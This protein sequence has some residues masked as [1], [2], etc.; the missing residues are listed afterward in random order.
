[1]HFLAEYMYLHIARTAVSLPV[2]E[3]HAHSCRYISANRS[4]ETDLSKGKWP[5]AYNAGINA[6]PRGLLHVEDEFC[7]MMNACGATLPCHRCK[8]YWVDRCVAVRSNSTE[9]VRRHKV[10]ANESHRV[11]NLSCSGAQDWSRR[12][13]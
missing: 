6:S 11:P 1:M 3:G 4:L 10:L 2:P 7:T 8:H 5:K 9:K 13:G 12:G